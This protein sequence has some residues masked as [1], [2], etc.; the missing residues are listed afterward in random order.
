MNDNEE[1]IHF[2]GPYPNEI[3]CG[4]DVETV[5]STFDFEEVTCTECIRISRHMS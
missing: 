4:A 2:R 5:V 1:M 3:L